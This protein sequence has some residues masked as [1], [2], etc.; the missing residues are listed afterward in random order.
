MICLDTNGVIAREFGED[1]PNVGSGGLDRFQQHA[2]ADAA[3]PHLLAGQAKLL[4]QPY[5]LAAAMGEQLRGTGF[6]Q[7]RLPA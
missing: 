1:L 6:G 7:D 5:G 4:G 3:H 2:T